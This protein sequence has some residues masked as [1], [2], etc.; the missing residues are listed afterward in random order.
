MY[1]PGVHILTTEYYMLYKHAYKYNKYLLIQNSFI[2]IK[3]KLANKL[4]Y[5]YTTINR[6][7]VPMK[8][9]CMWILFKMGLSLFTPDYMSEGREIDEHQEREAL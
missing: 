4:I 2:P 7:V 6:E 1:S 9:K 5:R 3:I 8:Q